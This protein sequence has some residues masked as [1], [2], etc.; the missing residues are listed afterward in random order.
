M[1]SEGGDEEEAQNHSMLNF[2]ERYEQR[3]Q[4]YWQYILMLPPGENRQG[5]DKEKYY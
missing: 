4:L 1:K 5:K 2:Q 3:I